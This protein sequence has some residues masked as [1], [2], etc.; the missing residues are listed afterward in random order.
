[1]RARC[2]AASAAVGASPGTARRSQ[3]R[4]VIQAPWMPGAKVKAFDPTKGFGTL[5][6]DTG[7]EI[8]FDISVT[9][10]REPK[11]GDRAEV[12]LALG[13]KGKPK[14]AL[15]VFEREEDRA[16]AFAY[17][18]EQLRAFGFLRAWSVEQARAAA[19][20]IWDD[21]VPANLTRG[22]AGALLQRY[23]GETL[24]DRGRS[25][26][27]ITLD[28]RFRALTPAWIMDVAALCHAPVTVEHE[29]LP[30]ALAA[31]NTALAERNHADRLF[32]LDVGIDFY[33][34]ACRPSD[35]DSR[36]ATTAWLKL[37]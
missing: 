15:V 13:W 18:V 35:F 26:G 3:K 23:Y 7:E 24:G 8:P 6:L 16:P 27:V 4:P 30:L 21:G 1:M 25:E 11:P 33:V 34:I 31:I 17:G 10:R 37:G 12:T 36:I 28:R 2:G 20:Q 29:S 32:G 5:A 9:N 14:A 19:R 22:D